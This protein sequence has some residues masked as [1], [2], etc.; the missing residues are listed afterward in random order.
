MKNP[1]EWIQLHMTHES[2]TV[3]VRGSP[4]ALNHEEVLHDYLGGLPWLH[5]WLLRQV[6]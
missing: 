5:N 1:N 6:S 2:G 4:V 3:E